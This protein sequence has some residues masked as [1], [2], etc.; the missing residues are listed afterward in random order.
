MR[1]RRNSVAAAGAPGAGAGVPNPLIDAACGRMGLHA[2]PTARA[3]LSAPYQD[4]RPCERSYLCGSYGCHTGAKSSVLAALWPKAL[5]TGT[6]QIRPA[7]QAVAIETDE[8]GERRFFHW[9]ESSAAR[10]LMDLPETPVHT[11]AGFDVW[12]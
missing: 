7:C 8:R 5:R 11:P 2:Y 3:I 12:T 10:I 4:R 6:C 1:T 9:R